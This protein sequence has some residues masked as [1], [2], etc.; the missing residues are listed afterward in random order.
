MI[1]I[2]DLFSFDKNGIYLSTTDHLVRSSILLKS[3]FVADV[4][5]R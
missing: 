3:R 2:I 5:A 1:Q 4:I